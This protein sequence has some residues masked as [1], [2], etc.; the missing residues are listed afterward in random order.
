MTLHCLTQ[1]YTPRGLLADGDGDGLPDGLAARFSVGRTPGAIDVAARLGLESAALT[2]GFT[3]ADTPG[4]PVFF[5]PD[6]PEC[7]A[8]PC[9]PGHGVV[10]LLDGA[11]VVSG[12]SH[13]DGWAAARWLADTFPYTAPGG[14]LLSDLAGGRPVRQVLV[15]DGAVVNL[16]CGEGEIAAA[17]KPTLEATPDEPPFRAEAPGDLPPP[18]LAQLFTVAGLMSS[19]DSARHDRAGWQVQVGAHITPAEIAGLCELAARTGVEATGLRFPFAVAGETAGTAVRLA[20]QVGSDPVWVDGALAWA[21]GCLTVAGSP[22]ERAEAL[23]RAAESGLV[24]GLHATLF[25]RRAALPEQ[26]VP[27]GDL[28]FDVVLDPEWEVDRFR[29][30]W[31]DQALPGVTATAPVNVDLRISEPLALREALA[32]EIARDLAARGVAEARIRV[33][34]A[35][36]QGFHWLEEEVLPRLKELGPIARVE[37]ACAR[38]AAAPGDAP[39]ASGA[40]VMG[41]GAVP[42]SGQGLRGVEGATRTGEPLEMVIRWLQE[43]YPAD[44]MLAAQLSAQVRFDLTEGEQGHIYELKAYRTDGSL[45]F[46]EGFSPVYSARTYLPEFPLRGRVHPSTGLLRVAQGGSVL[47]ETAFDTDAE[48]FWTAYQAEILPRLRQYV[49]EAY[50]SAPDPSAQP[51]FGA[52]VVEAALSEDDRRLGIR[53]EQISPLDALHEDL[54]FYTLDY[55]N[56]LGLTLTGKGYPA[57]GAVEPWVVSG[58]GGPQARVRLYARPQVEA[59]L[60][61]L[62]ERAADLPAPADAIPMDVVIGPDQL[63]PYLAYLSGLPGVRVWRTGLS[64]A[65]RATWALSVTAPTAGR[66]APPQKLSAWRPTLMVNSRR[67]ANEVSSTNSILKLAELAAQQGLVRQVNLVI[68]PMENVDGAAIH[69]AMQQVHPT[70][71]LHAARF[72]AAGVDFGFDLFRPEPQ[73][74]EARTLPTLWRSFLPDVLMDDH[75]YPSHEWVQPFSGYNSAP[76]FRTSWWMP[77]ALIY[78]IHRWMDAERFPENGALQEGIRDAM[79]DRLTAVPEIAAYTDTLLDRY[80]TYGQR[81]VP[82]KFPLQMHKGFVSLTG[83]VAAG[84]E[85]RSFV[86]RFPHITGA[87]VIT[88]VPD[89]TAQGD[90]LALCARA[91]LEGDLAVLGHLAGRPQPVVRRRSVVDGQVLWTVGRVR[92]FRV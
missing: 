65:G 42:Q 87:E 34:S 33:L 48:A 26:L 41:A 88:E 61:A 85:A 52:L 15:R 55:L 76:Y 35:Y 40:A 10:A 56:E 72:N 21:P 8:V 59:A 67:H 27:R 50:G 68:S 69:Y 75:G 47:L 45:A 4:V 78:G 53:E 16:L 9:P 13:A 38:F 25:T 62:P 39:S 71:K 32:E 20:D 82:E 14:Q 1:L 64:F 66:I 74:G 2:P 80:V 37:V 46:S 70:W 43:L 24:D 49:T 63:P 79:A 30:L 89:E 19:S 91:H 3:R 7:P 18:G 73:F 77:N 57:P 58:E 84:P 6:N 28:L 23:R 29:R 51:F 12:A 86:G 36:K 92:P 44:E 17:D 31:T 90:Y 54:Y 60:G 81:Y 5:G 22:G 83:K 11:V